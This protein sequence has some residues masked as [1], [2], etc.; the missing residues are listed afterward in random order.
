[1]HAYDTPG[2]Q[3]LKVLS[4]GLEL[5][6]ANG[7]A[8]RLKLASVASSCSGCTRA[9]C[10]AFCRFVKIRCGGRTR[11][12]AMSCCAADLRVDMGALRPGACVASLVLLGPQLHSVRL[13]L[14]GLHTHSKDL[15]RKTAPARR[16]S[17]TGRRAGLNI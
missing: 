14:Q 6:N 8:F 13:A 16:H 7:G 10:G 2:Q 3:T 17:L 1:M 12:R 4:Q 5:E 9:S 15:A 11:R